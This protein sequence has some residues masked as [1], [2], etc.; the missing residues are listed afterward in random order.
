MQPNSANDFPSVRIGTIGRACVSNNNK[1]YQV[2]T[3]SLDNS[4]AT[5]ADRITEILRRAGWSRAS[6]SL[7]MREALLRLFEDL[8]GKDPEELFRYFMNRQAKRAQTPGKHL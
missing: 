4:E 8:E 6:R 3:V 5:E 2:V 1:R 7:V